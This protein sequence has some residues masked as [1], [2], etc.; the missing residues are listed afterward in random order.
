MSGAGKASLAVRAVSLAGKA[1]RVIDPMT[2]VFKGAGAGLSKIGDVMAGLRGM[3]AIEIPKISDGAFSLPEGALELP[4]GTI[5][6]PEGAAIPEG[7]LKLPDGSVKL[8]EGTVTLPPGTVKWPFEDGPAKYADPAGNLYKEDGSL[9]QRAEEA[10]AEGSPTAAADQPRAESPVL[11]AVGARG[12]DDVIRLGSDLSDPV[13]VADNGGHGPGGFDNT[14]TNRAGERG[15]PAGAAGETAPRN[16]LDPTPGGATAHPEGT[17]GSAPHGDGSSQGGVGH[18]DGPATGGHHPET[19][20]TGGLDDAAHVGSD[21]PTPG[22]GTPVPDRF[23][24]P[25]SFMRQEG[26]P[27]GPPGSLKPE[28]ITEIQVYRANHEEGYFKEYYEKRGYRQDTDVPDESGFPPPQL[29]KDPAD[30]KMWLAKDNAPPAFPTKYYEGWDR[31]GTAKQLNDSQ[32]QSVLDNAARTRHDAI[33]A[34]NPLHDP[35]GAA[36][37]V[38]ERT[39]TPESKAMYDALKAG[40]APF[41]D[42]MSK[43]TEA[44]GEAVARHHVVSQFYEGAKWE[45]TAGPKNGNDQFDQVWRRK[46]DEGFVVIEAKSDVG[47]GIN[48]R[49]LPSGYKAKQGSR[50]YFLDIMNEMWKRA[51]NGDSAEL[52][53]YTD[54]KNAL[55]ADKVE[56]IL[57]KGVSDGPTYGGFKSRRFNVGTFKEEDFPFE[58]TNRSNP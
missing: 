54:L 43:A 21:L 32:A 16:A 40:H 29:I 4:D 19:P 34:D 47:T 1:G 23:P 36:K 3:G 35:L 12:G 58:A 38:W 25:P 33:Q 46:N 50:E 41:H 14:P 24:H 8:P 30:P 37:K 22:G 55:M 45:P 2:Y 28:Q 52:K 27:Y 15:A 11:A 39:K 49:T 7:A 44:Y 13:H 42:T 51:E 26:N 18:T 48:E 6:L 20:G 9:F 5:H 57:V 10:K 31:P 53:L 17:H 56:Y